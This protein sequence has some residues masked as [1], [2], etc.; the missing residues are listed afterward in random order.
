MNKM[1]RMKI[2]P[3]SILICMAL[4]SFLFSITINSSLDLSMLF[5]CI[6]DTIAYSYNP[7][8]F[9]KG[10]ADN[11]LNTLHKDK[12]FGRQTKKENEK[13]AA[14]GKKKDF[15]IAP[16]FSYQIKAVKEI[17][18]FLSGKFLI[19][20]RDRLLINNSP[21]GFLNDS[22]KLLICYILLSWFAIIF[23][24]KWYLLKNI[25]YLK[26]TYNSAV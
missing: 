20:D 17:N 8:Q 22:L 19:K 24:K 16:L 14:E 9:T 12:D 10:L 6:A 4:N 7:S 23:R 11:L 25:K 5:S 21:A 1:L 13:G 26:E 15:I 18:N 2:I 3:Y